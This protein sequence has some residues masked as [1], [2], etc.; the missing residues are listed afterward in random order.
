MK[1]RI[2]AIAVDANTRKQTRRW[3]QTINSERDP[4][5][6]ERDYELG[7]NLDNPN[8]TCKAVNM[9]EIK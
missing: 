2:T 1:Y 5:S 4:Y 8:E 9:E 7:W 3:T 6:I